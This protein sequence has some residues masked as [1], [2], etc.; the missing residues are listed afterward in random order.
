MLKDARVLSLLFMVTFSALSSSACNAG[1]TTI[2]GKYYWGIEVEAISP[3]GSDVSY[4][5]S[6]ADSV[7]SVARN[8]AEKLSR[9]RGE[10]YQPVYVK[11][12]GDLRGADADGFS[13]DYDGVFFVKHVQILD[14]SDAN[15][16][17]GDV[18]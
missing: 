14:S 11:L 17:L 5:V 3:C 18:D 15:S 7:L 8:E 2:V 16:C 13:S 12:V 4:W 10:P 6:G 9:E 1:T